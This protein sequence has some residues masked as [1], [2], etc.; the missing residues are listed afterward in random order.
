MSRIIEN[1]KVTPRSSERP[2]KC[3]KCVLVKILKQHRGDKKRVYLVWHIPKFCLM[4][5][6]VSSSNTVR[7]LKSVL[8]YSLL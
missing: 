8:F 1:K 7:F 5:L 4:I 3:I 6:N 2:T